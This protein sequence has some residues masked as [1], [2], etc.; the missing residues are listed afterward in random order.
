MQ[1]SSAIALVA[2]ALAHQALAGPGQN[3]AAICKAT[4]G[5]YDCTTNFQIPYGSEPIF[6]SGQSS[7][8]GVNVLAVKRNIC[9]M[10][11]DTLSD[12]GFRYGWPT[13]CITEDYATM[14]YKQ[15]KPWWVNGKL[16]PPFDSYVLSRAKAQ[17]EDM[18]SRWELFD[19]KD[20]VVAKELVSTDG[21]TLLRAPEVGFAPTLISHRLINSQINTGDYKELS[22]AL[23]CV[24]ENACTVAQLQR[25]S[26]WFAAWIRKDTEIRNGKLSKMLSGWETTFAVNYKKRIETIKTAANLVQTRLK[27]VSAKVSATQKKVCVNNACK[28]K[29]ATANLSKIS[30]TLQA[31]KN[32][33]DIVAAAQKAQDRRQSIHDNYL[34][35]IQETYNL[36]PEVLAPSFILDLFAAKKMDTMRDIMWG[37][38]TVT[39]GL[40]KYAAD[41]KNNLSPLILLTKHESRGR[42]VLSQITSV[43]APQWKT[44]KELSKTASSRQVRDGFIQI[45]SAINSELRD[46]VVQLIRAIDAFNKDLLKFPLRGG[47]L[48][49]AWGASSFSRWVNMEFEYP[50]REDRE[51]TYTAPG[52]SSTGSTVAVAAGF[53]P[54]AVATETVG[55]I[56]TPSTCAALYALKPTI[57]IQDTTGLYIMT[58]FFD[59]PGPMAKSASDVCVVAEILLDRTFDCR[60][61]RSWEGLS[62]GFL[63]PR[64]WNIAE[65][66]CIQFQGTAEQMVTEYEATVSSL[67]SYGCHLK[68]PIN[69]KDVSTLPPAILPIAYWDFKNVCIPKFIKAF[70]ECPV[71]CVADIVKFNRENSE[72][73]LPAPFT[74]QNDLEAAMK[75]TDDEEYIQHLKQELRATA[76]QVLDETFEKEQINLI[77]APG[78]SSLCV[79]AAAAGYPLATVP[80][81]QLCYNNRPFGLCIV[82]KAHED[83]TLLQ[84][85]MAYEK[86]VKPRPVPNI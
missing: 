30:A 9:D 86:V 64:V 3:L 52:G 50:C 15:Y 31:T 82:G 77:A 67:K 43:L 21:W 80:V 73:A 59:S 1:L 63:D 49:I 79:H 61:L 7:P 36:E 51:K 46:P 22:S 60:L 71:R 68:Y 39:E 65:D 84:F 48:E 10:I 11:L 5:T 78:D 56:V 44:N 38:G 28:G 20:S 12:N 81:G 6:C 53:S 24:R 42:A 26:D 72:K 75:S 58:E 18:I 14:D 33:A 55:F 34:G 45:Q 19:N 66:L 47:K 16:L 37:F 69:L 41:I 4:E 54:L 85:M 2:W 35:K 70:D 13:Y 40:S 62:V 57:G 74:E 17:A 76:K 25:I 83:E 32:L 29:T 23:T 8:C 27:T